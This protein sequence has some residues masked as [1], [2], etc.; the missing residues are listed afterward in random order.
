MA[1]RGHADVLYA[2][3]EAAELMAVTLN[4]LYLDC[5][6]VMMEDGGLV[7]GL[8][9][10]TD[11]F[12]YAQEIITDFLTKTE[13]NRKVVCIDSQAGIDTVTLPDTISDTFYAAYD[14]AY[15]HRTSAFFL[16][17]SDA[18]WSTYT[19]TPTTWKQDEV[20][21][22]Q[23]QI[24]PVPDF[25]GDP[26]GV[27][28]GQ[29]FYGTFSSVTPNLIT[30]DSS[31][32]LYGTIGGFQ[33]TIYVE[34]TAPMFGTISAMTV[35]STNLETISSAIPELF[36]TSYVL[37]TVQ[38]WP[39]QLI[40]DSCAL[41]LKYG[42]LARIF[43]MDGEMKDLAKSQYCSERYGEGISLWAAILSQEFEQE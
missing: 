32:A 37:S 42:I 29:G 27:D 30:I 11:F 6:K 12:T 17:N 8:C 22:K 4:S 26:V 23:L 2:G 24:S 5:C 15:L 16:D 40:P 20:S 1:W 21:P 43:G 36:P 38:F 9:S 19:N 25:S 34:P 39:I 10:S 41:Y 14:Q 28:L 33:G 35:S 7:L 31:A 3:N 13:I 18:G